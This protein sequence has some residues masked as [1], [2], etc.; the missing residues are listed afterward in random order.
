MMDFETMFGT[1][2]LSNILISD[3]GNNHLILSQIQ[4]LEVAPEATDKKKVT[5]LSVP[6]L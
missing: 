6:G 2:R 1:T 3:D 5:L 4:S